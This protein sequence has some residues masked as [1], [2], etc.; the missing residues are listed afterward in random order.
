MN[1]AV[2]QLYRSYL[3]E[4]SDP[5]AAASLALADVLMQPRPPAP[6]PPLTVPEIARLLR[7]R[8]TKVLSWIHAGRLKAFNVTEKEGGRPKFRVNRADLDDFM[9]LREAAQPAQ[10]GRPSRSRTRK[11]LA[12]PTL[13]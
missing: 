5:A 12:W 4:T 7:V 1:D 9:R 8:Q 13:D 3:Q 10:V 6:V 2:L 11:K